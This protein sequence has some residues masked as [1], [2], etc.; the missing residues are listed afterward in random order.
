MKISKLLAG[1]MSV[2]ALAAGLASCSSEQVEPNGFENGVAKYDQTHFMKVAVASPAG[3][4]SRADFEDGTADEST[5]N[6]L[7]FVFYDN[8]GQPTA[9]MQTFAEVDNEFQPGTNDN[10]TKFWT[11]VVPVNMVQGQNMP[12]YVMCYVNP[13]NLDGLGTYSL[14]EIQKSTVQTVQGA[15]GFAMCNSVYY[16]QDPVTGLTGPMLA[17]PINASNLFTSRDAA[18]AAPSLD[19]YVERYAAKI[20][21]TLAAGDI[22]PVTVGQV[23]KGDGEVTLNFTPTFWRP[24]A[25]CE[26]LYPTKAFGTQADATGAFDP[27]N[28]PSLDVMNGLFNGTTLGAGWNDPTNFRC[29]WACSPSYF[30]NEYP[31][32]SDDVDDLEGNTKD[33]SIKYFTYNDIAHSEDYK[34]VAW[35]NGFTTSNT[36][37]NASG[38]FYSRETTTNIAAIRNEET[39]NPAAAVASVVIVGKYGVTGADDLSADGTF[40]VDG[41]NNVFYANESSAKSAM[42]ERQNVLFTDN[43]GTTPATNPTLFSIKHPSKAVRGDRNVVGRYVT[44]QLTNL[45]GDE[46]QASTL[47]FWGTGE[48]GHNAYIPVTEENLTT[49]NQL[50]WNMTGNL[51]MY[52]QGLAFYNIPVH[53]LN[54]EDAKCLKE[55][56]NGLTKMYNWNNMPIGALGVVRNHVYNIEVSSITGRATGLRSDIQPIVPPKTDV[57]Y[58]VAARLNILA[59]KVV[60]TQKV[61]L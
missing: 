21:L 11:S 3:A 16:G 24:N 43:Q 38:Y 46:A 15:R 48:D 31:F 29:Y 2:F 52:Y 9:T 54:W 13:I 20:G 50:L 34:G 12:T 53:H 10:V 56:E 22:Q 25:I 8:Q 42:I 14:Q 39:G 23:G 28:T 57:N 35:N 18:A 49:V 44:L 47:Y 51:E 27:L 6:Q 1:T 30:A 33:Y 7:V 59:W 17:T 55:D 19:I 4:F 5:V 37:A 32:V 61:E 26:N 41:N 60:P 36:G 40:Y 45:T 58:Y